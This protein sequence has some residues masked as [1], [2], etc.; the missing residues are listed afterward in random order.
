MGLG[1]DPSPV[2][3]LPDRFGNE[4]IDG[5]GHIVLDQVYTAGCPS[6]ASLPHERGVP[7]GR[8]FPGYGRVRDGV[9]SLARTS[10]H[11]RLYEVVIGYAGAA[12][13]G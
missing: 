12:G 13:S 9:G 1:A 4:G 6:P 5:T 2:D 7:H 11:M 8:W 3:A 10:S